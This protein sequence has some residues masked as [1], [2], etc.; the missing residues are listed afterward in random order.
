[1]PVSRD[2]AKLGDYGCRSSDPDQNNCDQHDHER[3]NGVHRNAQRAVVSVAVGRMRMRYL[4]HGQK[5]EK[6]QAH[7]RRPIQSTLLCR[8]TG[9]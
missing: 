5:R 2:S 3:R 6:D 1:M 8:G 9:A 7:N 4:N